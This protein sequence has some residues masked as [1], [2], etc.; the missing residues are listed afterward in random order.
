M[1]IRLIVR[2]NAG[3][4]LAIGVALLVPLGISLLYGDGSWESFLVPAAAMIAAGAAGIRF[5]SRPGRGREIVSNRDIYFS[6][7][8]AWVLAAMLGGIPYLMQGTFTNPLDSTFE[9]MSGFTTTGA[10][11]LSHIQAQTPSILFWRSMTQWLGGVGIVVL[12]VAV[13]PALGTE[14]SRLLGA[15]VS[16]LTGTRLTPRIGDTARSLIFIYLAISAAC[17]LAL[18]G[19]GMPLYDAVVHTFATVATGGFSPKSASIG[20]YH[21]LPIEAVLIF[22][23]TA[24]G[25]SFSLYY[26]LYTRRRPDALLS[27]EVVVY[28]GTMA[29]ATILVWG[30]LV[31]GGTYG[32]DWGRALRDSAFTVS[33]IMTTTGFVTAD[34]D[35]WGGAAKFILVLLMFVGGCAGST[36]GGIKVIRIMIVVRT[37]LQEIFHMV[38]P[39]AVTPLTIGGRTI[40]ERVRVATLGLFAA[41]ISVFALATVLLAFQPNLSMVSAAPAVAATLNVVG[42]G[43]GQVGAAENFTAVDPFG[44]GVLTVCM[45]FGRLE[46]FT[47]LALISPAFWRK[48]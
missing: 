30:L 35:K 48:A 14:A 1:N 39:R 25:I 36:A 43:L 5:T 9:G 16:G 27:R 8:L 45:L 46:L 34:F 20:F 2:L 38:H 33:S 7:T 29:G 41:W 3:V 15:E 11:L 44:R 17:T 26:V 47:A 32:P 42:P 21:S 37:N 31:Y 24:S 18:L 10:T 23:M 22:F 12:F 6:V 4:V 13:A 19:A 40:P 28:L